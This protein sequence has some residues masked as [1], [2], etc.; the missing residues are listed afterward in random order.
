MK[1]NIMILTQISIKNKKC[2]ST[3]AT[4]LVFSLGSYKVFSIIWIHKHIINP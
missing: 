1:V 4:M 3:G 2:E